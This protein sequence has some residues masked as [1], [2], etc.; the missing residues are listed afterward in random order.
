[1][2]QSKNT[3]LKLYYYDFDS[4]KIK[5]LPYLAN[6]IKNLPYLANLGV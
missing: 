1:M 4:F 2:N 6:L 5:N 3:Y